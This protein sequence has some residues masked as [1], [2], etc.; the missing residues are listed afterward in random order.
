MTDNMLPFTDNEMNVI[1]KRISVLVG[2]RSLDVWP[3]AKKV[4]GKS[5]K[6]ARDNQYLHA[7]GLSEMHWLEFHCVEGERI[8]RRVPNPDGTTFFNRDGQTP[9]N[10]KANMKAYKKKLTQVMEMLLWYDSKRDVISMF[11]PVYKSRAESSES[12]EH[13]PLA[14]AYAH[15]IEQLAERPVFQADF[16]TEDEFNQLPLETQLLVEQLH[17][18]KQNDPH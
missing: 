4:K 17:A 15:V 8:D 2:V 6:G 1:W 16:E 9:A 12:Q 3:H 7:P 13:N 10:A 5:K 14:K 18:F 11:P